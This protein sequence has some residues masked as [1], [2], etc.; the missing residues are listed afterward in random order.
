M[1]ESAALNLQDVVSYSSMCTSEIDESLLSLQRMP[2]LSISLPRIPSIFEHP[3]SLKRHHRYH[4]P[5]TEHKG[6][7]SLLNVTFNM[8]NAIIGTGILTI[9]YLF[10]N[11]LL[12]C[13][14]VMFS[15][16]VCAIYTWNILIIAG[17]RVCVFNYEV[18]IE[19]CFGLIGYCL[20]CL[21]IVI[22]N[23][24]GMITF[25]III[26]DALLQLLLIFNLDGYDSIAM[27][28]L[29][30]V[31]ILPPCLFRD[32][33]ALEKV[34]L[35]KM[36]SLLMIILVVFIE[37]GR[38]VSNTQSISK[39][40]R[41]S[42]SLYFGELS[43]V[44]NMIGV[45]AFSLV[46]HDSS[47]LLYQTMESPTKKR[48][49]TLSVW[50]IFGAAFF[51]LLLTIPCY[52]TFGNLIQYNM[53]N[54]YRIRDPLVIM[55]RIIFIITLSLTY[56][57]AFFL[58]RH[59]I[60]SSSQKVYAMYVHGF[61]NTIK[62]KKFMQMKKMKCI[63]L[64]AA[65]QLNRDFTFENSIQNT[66]EEFDERKAKRLLL[67]NEIYTVQS[68]PLS[69]HLTLTLCIFAANL[70]CG[71]YLKNLG[72]VMGII[73]SLSSVHLAFVFPSL[74]YLKTYDWKQLQ[75]SKSM[76]DK[77]YGILLNIPAVALIITGILLAIYGVISSVA[78]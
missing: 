47:F 60:Y 13:I 35:L 46:C 26:N 73:G 1:A 54:N 5:Y 59:V 69:H 6:N 29:S 56:P 53:L 37:F 74:V 34:S 27:L 31:I 75:N 66:G 51:I 2:S 38:S 11:G 62:L 3:N 61:E 63:K 12:C 43:K 24:G 7:S 68:A 17:K 22:L 78:S 28:I 65:G 25:L 76:T 57:S 4:C 15:F 42:Y 30:L 64:E 70:V 14:I 20:C 45:V 58:V 49:F 50:G 21:C 67:L 9:P 36:I 33:S 71:M 10:G 23:F 32:L 8:L 72:L 41:G 39:Q 19:E 52:L 40:T 77:C 16:G 18:L 44:P 55:M 48:W